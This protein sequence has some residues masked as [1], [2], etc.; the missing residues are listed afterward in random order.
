MHSDVL[1]ARGDTDGARRAARRAL[2]LAPRDPNAALRCGELALE[3]ADWEAA[4]PALQTA[5]E[6]RPLGM[7][8][9]LLYGAALDADGRA[10]EL[11]RLTCE[12]EP[13]AT[14]MPVDA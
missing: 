13:L 12:S 2:E 1:R 10:A 7:R 14:F 11:E 8:A 4:V 6:Y 5:V 3:A 9:R